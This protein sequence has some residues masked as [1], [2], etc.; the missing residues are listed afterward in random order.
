[1]RRTLLLGFLL[2]HSIAATGCAAKH[3]DEMTAFLAQPAGPTPPGT[4]VR[5][6]YAPDGPPAYIV[7]GQVSAKTPQGLE[8]QA[9]LMGADAVIVSP[10]RDDNSG[11]VMA[12]AIRVRK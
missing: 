6:Y 5:V 1:M 10:S 7:L 4:V 3:Q 2:A 9:R 8:E 11:M 12:N